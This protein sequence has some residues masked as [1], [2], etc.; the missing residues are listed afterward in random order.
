MTTWK[1]NFLI[2]GVLLAGTDGFA[3]ERDCTESKS[4]RA[5]DVANRQ[6]N[7]DSLHR[8]YRLYL[9]CDDGAVGEG[10]SESV[11]RTLVDHWNTLPDLERLAKKD[12]LFRRFVLNHVNA[13]LN[14]DD[15]EIIKK[16]AQSKCPAPSHAICDDL[17]RQADSAIKETTQSR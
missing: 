16:K 14:V 10:Y 4:R 5:L 6:R 3:Q 12:S 13:T 9:H 2:V 8:S 15:L 7:W 11:A 17:I 1:I